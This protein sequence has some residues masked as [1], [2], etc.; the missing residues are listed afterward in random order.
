MLNI[1]LQILDDGHITDAHGR[2][3]NF[4]NTVIVMTTNLA[5]CGV[6]SP[7]GFN[8][9][10]Q[11]ASEEKVRNALKD[12]LRPEFLNRIDEIVVFSPL[13]EESFE[14][15]CA[16]VLSDL[17]KSLAESNI[18]FEWP[19]EVVK[20]IVKKSFDIKYGARNLQRVVQ[21]DIEN[22]I[23]NTVIASYDKP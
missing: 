13:T 4:E 22:E 15:I 9:P 19:D 17:K 7:A 2:K 14:K 10:P 18:L 8:K 23:A 1:L 12:F 16:I 21:R 3:V 5:R 6:Q 11:A 20:E